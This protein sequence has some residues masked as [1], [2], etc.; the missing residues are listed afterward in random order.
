[1]YNITLIFTRHQESGICNST[2]L[3]KIIKKINSEII[4]EELSHTT[5]DEIYNRKIQTTL[6]TNA[7][8]KYLQHHKVEHIPVD[9]YI[10]PNS[11]WENL[12]LMYNRIINNNKIEESYAFR[13]L[14]DN[15]IHMISQN[16]FSYLNSKKNDEL[17]EEINIL[18]EK[19][20]QQH[21]DIRLV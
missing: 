16:G 2:E 12:E 10:L 6:E 18:K 11:Y 5:F 21:L 15:E 4:F 8:K 14:L 1:M 7:I 13:N 20:L 9:T 19:I 3:H 17:F